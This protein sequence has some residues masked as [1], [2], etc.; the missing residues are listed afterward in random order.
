MFKS[1][2]LTLVLCLIFIS[3]IHADSLY[4]EKI[5]IRYEIGTDGTIFEIQ[6]TSI[7]KD[8]S[9]IAGKTHRIIYIPGSDLSNASQRIKDLA[10]VLWSQDKKEK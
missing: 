1:I 2:L 6:N 9:I 5:D 10:S 7:I 4:T 3:N 8:G